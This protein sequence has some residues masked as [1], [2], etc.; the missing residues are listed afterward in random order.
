CNSSDGVPPCASG[1][2]RGSRCRRGYRL[3]AAATMAGRSDVSLVAMIKAA[4]AVILI[5]A[6]WPTAPAAADDASAGTP[7]PPPP[8]ADPTKSL[9]GDI[10]GLRSGLTKLG[11]TPAM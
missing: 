1:P 3:V 8:G 10:G 4:V 7:A 9:L 11:L 5:A 2:W 6:L